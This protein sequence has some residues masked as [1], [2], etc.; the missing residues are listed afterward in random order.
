MRTTLCS[1]ALALAAATAL[2][3]CG[4]TSSDRPVAEVQTVEVVVTK[5]VPCP[6][7]AALGEPPAY[8]DTD[9][10]IRAAVTMAERALLYVTGRKMRIQRESEYQT[11]ATACNF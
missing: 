3:G 11:A 1:V 5:S 2:V 4:T 10:A 9:E 6:A 7:L 8:P